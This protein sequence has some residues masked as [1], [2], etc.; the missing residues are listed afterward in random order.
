MILI[1]VN[2]PAPQRDPIFERLQS[3]LNTDVR[4]FVHKMDDSRGWGKVGSGYSYLILDCLGSWLKL[5]RV[6]LSPRL[7]VVYLFGYR[8]LARVA[9]AVV[10]RSRRLPLVIRSDSNVQ[11]HISRSA[12]FRL[13]KRWFLRALLGQPEIWVIGSANDE[14]W[15]NLGFRRRYLVPY[16]VPRLPGGAGGAATFRVNLQLAEQFTFS[17]VG[18]LMPRK[19]IRDLLE[20]YEKVRRTV[21]TGRTAL[22]FVGRGPLE[23]E[24]RQYAHECADVHL[25]GALPY[26]RLGAVYAATDILVVPSHS[27]PWGFVVNESLGFGTPVIVS[28]RIGAARDLCTHDNS[29]EFPARDPRALADAML[30]EYSRGRRRVAPPEP[31][32]AAATMISRLEE[33]LRD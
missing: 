9:A 7:R 27:E 12:S 26:D 3:E 23:L 2:C 5:F 17:Y 30:T 14:Y 18:K 29:I 16:T 1:I 21:G 4:I 20:A 28:D 25:V 11:D 6:L 10:G 33:L 22:V 8:G 31:S 19:G 15:A 13:L 32:D 24:I